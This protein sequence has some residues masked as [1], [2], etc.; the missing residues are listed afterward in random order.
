[1]SDQLKDLGE[2]RGGSPSASDSW[3]LSQ[4]KTHLSRVIERALSGKPQ[5]IVRGRRDA[6][7]VVA[8]GAYLQAT[9]PKRSVVELFS[10]LRGTGLRLEREDDFGRD[11]PL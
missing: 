7:V 3:N 4:A 2:P 9:R 5:R 6:V 8:E 1:M 10:A 11:V